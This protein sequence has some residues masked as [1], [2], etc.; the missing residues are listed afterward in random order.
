MHVYKNKFEMLWEKFMVVGIL[1]RK[2]N[3]IYFFKLRFKKICKQSCLQ[4]NSYTRVGGG[5]VMRSDKLKK[6]FSHPFP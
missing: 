4:L 5:F 1:Q 2:K 6:D 3:N